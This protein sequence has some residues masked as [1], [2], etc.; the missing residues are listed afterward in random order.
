MTPLRL[1]AAFAETRVG[2]AS[3]TTTY[4]YAVELGHR[5]AFR[6]RATDHMGNTREWVEV[7]RAI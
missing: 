3:I 5:Y 2:L 4:E 1:G 7:R 6:V